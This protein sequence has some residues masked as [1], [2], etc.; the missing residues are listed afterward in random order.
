[1]ET[2][3]NIIKFKHY[4]KLAMTTSCCAVYISKAAKTNLMVYD[5]IAIMS[6]WHFLYV[7]GYTYS[8]IAYMYMYICALRFCICLC[9]DNAVF[10]EFS[11]WLCNTLDMAIVIIS[12]VSMISNKNL[13]NNTIY[14]P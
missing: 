12:V 14:N 3:S 6:F 5:H 11:T 2:H 7:A 9:H 13:K 8:Y 10:H 1:M 4:I